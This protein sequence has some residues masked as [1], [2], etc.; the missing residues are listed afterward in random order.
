[1]NTKAI[2]CAAENLDDYVRFRAIKEGVQYSLSEEFFRDALEAGYRLFFNI[3]VA[4]NG[5]LMRDDE[6]PEWFQEWIRDE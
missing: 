5:Q 6:H 3:T 2:N 4:E 1:M